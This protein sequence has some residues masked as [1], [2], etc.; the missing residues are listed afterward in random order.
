[1]MD[2][3][4]SLLHTTSSWDHPL[5]RQVTFELSVE[6]QVQRERDSIAD[7]WKFD[8]SDEED[9]KFDKYVT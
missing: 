4:V 7:A 9:A 5:T 1:M 6:P 3:Y 2:Q 8:A